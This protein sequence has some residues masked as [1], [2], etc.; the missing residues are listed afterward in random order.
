[1]TP[2]PGSGPPPGAGEEPPPRA[3]CPAPPGA[4]DGAAAAI[5]ALGGPVIVMLSGGR[6]SVCL[7]DL[8]RRSGAPVTV[9][10]VNYGLR[11]A[12]DA[13]EAFCRELWPDVHVVWAAEPHGNVQEWA[14]EVRYAA[15]H[16]LEGT[17]LTGHTATDQ[18]ETI[19][20]RLLS[21]GS[22][23]GMPERSGRVF[24]PLLGMTRAQT[25][26]YCVERGLRW[27]EDASNASSA[28][29]RIRGLLALHPG[30]EA[31]VIRAWEGGRLQD[32]TQ[33]GGTAS[34]DLA[35]GM[36]AISEYG[37][38]TIGPPPTIGLPVPGR[39]AFGAG[40]VSCEV[41]EFA[42]QDGAVEGLATLVEVRTWRPGDKMRPLGLGG[43][44]SLQDLFT[45][46]KIP[47]R[48]RHL[49]PVVIS[50]GEIAWVPGVATGERFRVRGDTART[51]LAFRLRPR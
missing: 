29:G 41:G 20:F 39:V 26:A 49:L 23:T 34:L 15:A 19:L 9:L 40:E 25:T 5:A 31:N 44:K 21:R 7:L 24:R 17:I 18:A 12:A 1:M 11:E 38:L 10:H 4:A 48:Q 33:H 30:A 47:R 22:L 28:R 45:D 36:Q 43:T 27:R 42:L 14:R 35:G 3:G 32:L 16:E 2:E 50:D 37:R 13:D 6:D 8:A 51:R 46:R